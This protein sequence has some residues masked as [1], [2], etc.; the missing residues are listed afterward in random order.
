M[1]ESRPR[2]P[3]RGLS[4]SDL[5]ELAVVRPLTPAY[6]SSADAPWLSA[7]LEERERFV[8]RPRRLWRARV[9]EPWK[10]YVPRG[11]LRVALRVLDRLAHDRVSHGCPSRRIRERLFREATRCRDRELALA[12]AGQALG[13]SQAQLLDGLFA[14]LPDERVLA[15]LAKALDPVQL[16]LL[17]NEALVSELLCRALRVRI[18]ARGQVR[19]VVRHA[20]RVGLLCVV[21][22][23]ASDKEASLEVSGPYALFRHTRLYGRALASLVPR[24]ARCDVYRLEADCV[25]AGGAELGRLVLKSGDPI[26]PAREL[27]AYDS[28]LEERFV[29]DFGKLALEWDVIREPSPIRVGSSLCFPD[30]LLRHRTTAEQYWLEIVG[31]WT[32][33]YLAKKLQRLRAAALPRLIVCVDQSRRCFEGE[34][35]ELGAVVWFTRRI[36]PHAVLALIEP[37]RS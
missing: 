32:P 31:Y 8:G 11:K 13:L 23:D 5:R 20:K 12:A 18:D 17:C 27:P 2:P 7:L 4:L 28:R 24:L 29:R 35:H 9:L 33:Q 16:S 37:D 25:L 30:F 15:P 22:S 36:D 1:V 34:W 21:S 6:V 14:D 26:T 19:A 10:V 3:A